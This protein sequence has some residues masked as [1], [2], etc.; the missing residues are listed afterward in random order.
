MQ[1]LDNFISHVP[2][3]VGDLLIPTIPIS[4]RSSS[5]KVLE[6]LATMSSAD[7]SRTRTKKRRASITPTPQKK[8]KKSKG[9]SPGKIKINEPIPTMSASTPPAGIRKGIPIHRSRRYVC[10]NIPCCRVFSTSIILELLCRMP[11][12]INLDSSSKGVPIDS[13][14]ARLTSPR[15]LSSRGLLKSSPRQVSPRV[16]NLTKLYQ[17]L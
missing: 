11:Q 6:N 16:L 13:E 2:S 5:G 7:A 8:A 15:V 3:F 9:R 1:T 17:N 10:L 4:A 14:P 12:D